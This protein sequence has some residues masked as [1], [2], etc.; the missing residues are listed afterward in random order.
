MEVK[1][2][3]RQKKKIIKSTQNTIPAQAQFQHVCLSTFAYTA[4]ACIAHPPTPVVAT[5]HPP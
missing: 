2:N 3:K 4:F 5:T 1:Y